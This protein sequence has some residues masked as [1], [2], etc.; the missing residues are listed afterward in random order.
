MASDTLQ[1]K[2][3]REK[4]GAGIMA[5]KEA[6]AYS[7]GDLDK[8]ITYL[9]QKGAAVAGSKA[10]RTAREGLISS[11]IHHGGRLGVLLEVNC[12]TDF[13]ARTNEFRAFVHDLAIQIAGANPPPLYVSPEDI[14]PEVFQRE[15][16]VAQDEAK[17][18]GKPDAVVAQIVQGK[19]DKWVS[20]ICL[21]EQPSIR[22]PLIKIKDLLEQVIA[23]VGEKIM[24]RR[25]TRY[26]LGGE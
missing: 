5:C 1:I 4:T 12:E 14:P 22:D 19:L 6:L 26:Q 3:L 7:H 17:K 8:A 18:T 13:V 20:S 10:T 15:R 24:V 21:L 23:R 25:F 2:T 16:D 9:R 11:Y